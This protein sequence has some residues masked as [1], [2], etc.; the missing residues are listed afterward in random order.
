[1]R[2]ACRSTKGRR[3][4]RDAAR[5]RGERPPGG[6]CEDVRRLTG[7]PVAGRRVSKLRS[8]PIEPCRR[9]EEWP[10]RGAHSDQSGVRGPKRGRR[11][12]QGC[13]VFRTGTGGAEL[14]PS[15]GS[16][17]GKAL[18][19]RGTPSGEQGSIRQVAPGRGWTLQVSRRETLEKAGNCVN[20]R[21]NNRPN[22]RPRTTKSALRARIAY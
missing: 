12:A 16:R 4:E 13:P 8:G 2:P 15:T 6:S 1:M 19:P 5:P 10:G 18:I 9:R 14:D 20:Y 11:I 3:G 7:E 21:P 17:S 22:G